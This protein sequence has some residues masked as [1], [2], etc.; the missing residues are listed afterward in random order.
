MMPCTVSM[1]CPVGVAEIH[2]ELSIPFSGTQ[3]CATSASGNVALGLYIFRDRYALTPQDGI[4]HLIR[5]LEPEVWCPEHLLLLRPLRRYPFHLHR[6][7]AHTAGE[8]LGSAQKT[9]P[10]R[11]CL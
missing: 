7:S 3:L 8:G 10:D 4:D 1:L 2:A 9:Q 5:A 11:G 6:S